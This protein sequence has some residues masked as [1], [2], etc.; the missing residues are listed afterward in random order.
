MTIHLGKV[1][2]YHL[3]KPETIHRHYFSDCLFKS[4]NHQINITWKKKIFQVII[5]F[6]A[7]FMP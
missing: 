6:T 3:M 4:S 2:T 7:C 5:C 1:S